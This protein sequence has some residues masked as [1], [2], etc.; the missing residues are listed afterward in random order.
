MQEMLNDLKETKELSEKAGL[1]ESVATLQDLIER[2]EI[3]LYNEKLM[4]Y[5]TYQD[6]KDNVL[7]MIMKKVKM[8]SMIEYYNETYNQNKS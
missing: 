5:N 8:P 6:C 4:I 1:K 3:L 2:S 7:R